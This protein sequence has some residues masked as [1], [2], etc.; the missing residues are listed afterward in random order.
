[1]W[2]FVLFD[3]PTNSK[4]ERK[5][6]SG[7]RKNLLKNGFTMMQQSVYTRH[8]A[9]KESAEAH[10]KRIKLSLPFSGQISII[11]I[12]D[13][14]YGNIIN[15]WGITTKPLADQPKQLELF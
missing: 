15:Y 8:C 9:S 7:F 13:K 2:L 10:I 1:M 4:K 11:M 14:Q 3:L 5:S 12:T 6:A